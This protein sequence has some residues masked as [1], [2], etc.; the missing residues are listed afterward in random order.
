MHLNDFNEF[1]SLLQKYGW[2][3]L[4]HHPLCNNFKDHTMRIHGYVICKG[5]FYGY[6]GCF[7]AF[8]FTFFLPRIDYLNYILFMGIC[9]S[10]SRINFVNSLFK[11]M[12]KILLGCDLGFGVLAIL[13]APTFFI[14]IL[15]LNIFSNIA[16]GYL[17][18]RYLK[19]SKIC[20][21]CEHYGEMPD[22][23]GLKP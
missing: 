2:L 6:I 22:C 16:L 18:Y 4:A 17:G 5:C 9:F 23:P 3:F 7:L 8:L 19:L 1:R 14:Q 13:T 10:L 11:S 12:T 21:A 20:L 15:L